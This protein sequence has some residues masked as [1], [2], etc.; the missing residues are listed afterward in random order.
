MSVACYYLFIDL[1]HMCSSVQVYT[2][3]RVLW[4][5]LLLI[6]TGIVLYDSTQPV[7]L[8]SLVAQSVERALH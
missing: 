4:S 3:I 2:Y 6:A 1:V 8:P 7:K 5:L